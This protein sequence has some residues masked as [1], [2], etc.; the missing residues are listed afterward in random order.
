MRLKAL[1]KK[2]LRKLLQALARSLDQH[3]RARQTV[4]RILDR[5]GIKDWVR[6]MQAPSRPRKKIELTQRGREIRADLKRA[7]AAHEE[8]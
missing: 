8:P 6:R 4:M 2:I 3:P 1:I 7:L 5:L